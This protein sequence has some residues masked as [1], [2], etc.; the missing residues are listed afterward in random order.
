MGEAA[1]VSTRVPLDGVPKGSV[2]DILH[3][4]E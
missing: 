2:V 4:D 1:V 3:R